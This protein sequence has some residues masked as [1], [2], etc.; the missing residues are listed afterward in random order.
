[1]CLAKIFLNQES[2]QPIMQE[3]SRI[4]F[5]G[6]SIQIETLFGEGKT[7]SGKLREIDFMSSKVILESSEA[8][9]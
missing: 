8:S 1:M 2:D 3:I 7:I 5:D 6:E 9:S 4:K